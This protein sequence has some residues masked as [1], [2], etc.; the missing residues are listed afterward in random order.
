M[1]NCAEIVALN[2][3]ACTWRWKEKEFLSHSWYRRITLQS[4]S[5]FLFR[6]QQMSRKVRK[7]VLIN[8]CRK[9]SSVHAADVWLRSLRF[10][11]Y[12]LYSDCLMWR[13][14]SDTW[15][16]WQC[17]V[18]NIS[19][20]V[21]LAKGESETQLSKMTQSE[22]DTYE[23]HVRAANIVSRTGIILEYNYHFWSNFLADHGS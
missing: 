20:I 5:I 1:E 12:W 13:G 16:L 2:K 6:N 18:C 3:L 8:V 11:L 10:K 19:E 14:I 9:E 17:I 22:Q 21:K 4:P 15:K 23:M 7:S